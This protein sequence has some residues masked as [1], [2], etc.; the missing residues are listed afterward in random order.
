MRSR[1]MRQ[2]YWRKARTASG[3]SAN[4]NPPT[5]VSMRSMVDALSEYLDR[6]A[7]AHLSREP[8]NRPLAEEGVCLAYVTAGLE[9]PERIVWCGGRLEIAGAYSTDI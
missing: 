3:A 7:A 2:F 4:W 6:W 1:A 8:A 5:L 9:P